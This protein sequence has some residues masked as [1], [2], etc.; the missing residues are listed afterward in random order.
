MRVCVKCAFLSIWESVVVFW[1][2]LNQI[3]SNFKLTSPSVNYKRATFLPFLHEK[4]LNSVEGNKKR[5][6][7]IE[8][9]ISAAE[10]FFN[11]RF[12]FRLAQK[13][14]QSGLSKSEKSLAKRNATFRKTLILVFVNENCCLCKCFTELYLFYLLVASRAILNALQFVFS[15][16]WTSLAG[17]LKML[18]ISICLP[19]SRQ[20]CKT[21]FKDRRQ[22]MPRERQNLACRCIR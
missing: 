2:F 19:V 13:S 16:S 22:K 5:C 17:V 15:C 4:T 20:F 11:F 6:V 18:R 12:L 7:E 1:T 21:P 10:S 14:R 9:K 3:P 8:R